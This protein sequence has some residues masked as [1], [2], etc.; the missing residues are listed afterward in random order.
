MDT[1]ITK[2]VNAQ[3]FVD[4]LKSPVLWFVSLEYPTGVHVPMDAAL[5]GMPKMPF[6]LGGVEGF[7]SK[8]GIFT[9]LDFP[10]L[11]DWQGNAIR[12]I[13]IFEDDG[14]EIEKDYFNFG[15]EL[16]RV[17]SQIRGF[18]AR[19]PEV[20]RKSCRGYLQ[21]LIDRELK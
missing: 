14:E 18:W 16:D 15:A 6:D 7:V 21:R 2:L 20:D 9:A 17:R 4:S 13:E 11:T 19:C 1:G 12:R 8:K 10:D 5:W 3:D